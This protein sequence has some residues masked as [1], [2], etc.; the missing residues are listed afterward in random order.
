M[1]QLL[2]IGWSC[3]GLVVMSCDSLERSGV[4]IQKNHWWTTGR[5]SG[6]RMLTAPAKSQLTIG[7]HPSPV[8]TGS[9]WRKT[10]S[11]VRAGVSKLRLAGRMRP[12]RASHPARGDLFVYLRNKGNLLVS[13]QSCQVM[14]HRVLLLSVR[15]LSTSSRSRDKWIRKVTFDLQT[16]TVFNLCSMFWYHKPIRR[17]RGGWFSRRGDEWVS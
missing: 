3:R 15:L 10:T 17:K 8:K 14:C 7:H 13:R 12:A 6:P 11:S 16:T 4:L 9:V 5:A 1:L 2:E